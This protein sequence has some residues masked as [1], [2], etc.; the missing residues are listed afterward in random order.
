MFVDTAGPDSAP[1][2]VLLHGGIGT[3]GYHWSKIAR[4]LTQTHRVHLPDLSGHGRTPLPDDGSY[5][6]D[7]L[8]R[9]AASYLDDLGGPVH[10]GGFSM[11]GHTLLAL[12]Q[13]RPRLFASLVL[14]G[15]SIRAHAGLDAWRAR[16]HPDRLGKEHPLWARHLSRLHSPLGGPDAWRDVCR[17]DAAGIGIDV[18][19]RTLARLECPSC[20]YGGTAT[21]PWTPASTLSCA[22]PGRRR[23]SWSCPPAG[24][25]LRSRGLGWFCPRWSI[26]SAVYPPDGQHLLDG[27]KHA[28]MLGD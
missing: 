5:S 7:V 26:S 25:R 28:T 3:G 23:M 11:G 21:P 8:V 19:P 1:D 24:T 20:S 13:S 14:V 27:R 2:L 6:R 15:V 17:R 9:A 4:S 18:D 12:A 22:G 16:F 10:A